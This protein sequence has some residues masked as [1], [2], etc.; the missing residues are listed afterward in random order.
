[1]GSLDSRTETKAR[2]WVSFELSKFILGSEAA[3]N[4]IKQNWVANEFHLNNNNNKE[5]VFNPAWL[6]AKPEINCPLIVY[7]VDVTNCKYNTS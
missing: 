1:M 4:K 5:I 6:G 7:V 3:G 2:K